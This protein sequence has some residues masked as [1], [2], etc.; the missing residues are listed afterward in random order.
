M[1]KHFTSRCLLTDHF[2]HICEQFLIRG[3]YIVNKEHFQHG[4]RGFV[5]QKSSTYSRRCKIIMEQKGETNKRNAY[6]QMVFFLGGGVSPSYFLTFIH[7]AHAL[8]DQTDR[9]QSKNRGE[10]RQQTKC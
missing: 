2:L 9:I 7:L 1:L 5:E 3:K 4:F 8:L 10:K 6:I